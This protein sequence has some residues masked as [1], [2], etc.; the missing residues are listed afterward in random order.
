M[1]TREVAS[2]RE[3]CDLYNQVRTTG[4]TSVLAINVLLQQ[5]GNEVCRKCCDY[6]C[7]HVLGRVLTDSFADS[8]GQSSRCTNV[9]KVLGL[10]VGS[11]FCVLLVVNLGGQLE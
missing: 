11:Q 3:V 8:L 9:S 7:V 4:E 5:W 2:K 6:H 10:A 1:F